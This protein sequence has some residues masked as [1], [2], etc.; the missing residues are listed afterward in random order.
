[1]RTRGLTA[2]ESIVGIWGNM[3][4]WLEMV[5]LGGNADGVVM[6]GGGCGGGG[7][8]R[9]GGLVPNVQRQSSALRTRARLGQFQLPGDVAEPSRRTV[10]DL[11]LFPLC[12][13]IKASARCN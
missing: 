9:N 4:V 3:T 12:P 8:V 5:R 6:V 1:M 13:R 2:S 11:G 7:R 10:D